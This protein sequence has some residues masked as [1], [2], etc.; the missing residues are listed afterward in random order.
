MPKGGRMMLRGG[1]FD[2]KLVL[3]AIASRGY[4]P[5]VKRGSTS[6]GGYGARVRVEHV[7]ASCF[8]LHQLIY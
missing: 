7:A 6:S 3:N 5:M 8:I 1:A 4:V 2:A